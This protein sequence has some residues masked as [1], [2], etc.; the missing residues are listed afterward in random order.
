[1]LENYFFDR[2][3]RKKFRGFE[4]EPPVGMWQKIDEGLSPAPARPVFPHFMRVAASVAVL[5]LAGFSI[6]YI[7]DEPST[8]PVLSGLE[9]PSMVIPVLTEATPELMHERE[10]AARAI[11]AVYS[12]TQQTEETTAKQQTEFVEAQRSTMLSFSSFDSP[13]LRLKGYQ[14]AFESEDGEAPIF[15]DFADFLADETLLSS[16]RETQPGNF[17]LSVHFAPQYNHRYLSPRGES[18]FMGIPFENLEETINTYSFGLSGNF[19]ITRRFAVQTGLHYLNIGQYVDE[20]LAY[21]HIHK[22]EIYQLDP[23]RPFSH[24]QTIITSQGTIRLKD[25]S[26][27]FADVQSFRVMTNKQTLGFDDPKYLRQREKGLTQSFGYLEIPLIFRYMVFE[28]QV[29]IH[30][31]GGIT[32]NYLVRNE[33]FLGRDTRQESIGETHGLRN[34]NFSAI[35][36]FVMSVPLSPRMSLNLEPTAQIFLHSVGD[37]RFIDGRAFPYNFSLYSGISYRF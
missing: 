28:N 25:A 33:V 15:S 4:P 6:W 17:S 11:P 14:P 26:L 8:E 20:I 29:G 27:Y 32:G 3:V 23:G 1:M 16:N 37:N 13:E 7:W 22:K 2:R 10:A 31:K 35:G 5:L 19:N 36:G 30:L 24:P 21:G 34:V 12:E 9:S 18:G